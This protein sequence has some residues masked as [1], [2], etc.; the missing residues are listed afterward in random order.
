MRCLKPKRDF[1]RLTL[2]LVLIFRTQLT[3]SYEITDLKQIK[4][5]EFEITSVNLSNKG[6]SIF[7]E[8]I[9]TCPN[10]VKLDLS[11]NGILKIPQALS[12]MKELK[13]LNFSEN[14]GLSYL[15]LESLFEKAE[16]DLESLNLSDCQMGFI[17]YQIG[18]L[19]G[20]KILNVSGN[21]LND[22]PYPVT[23]LTK[24]EKV[25][26]SNNRIENLHW[27][28]GQWW[29]LK[30]LDISNNPSLKVN[31]LFLSLSVKESLEKLVISHI[32]ELPKNFGNLQ[33]NELVIKNTFMN[34]FPR[35]PTSKQIR[36]LS[37]ID[38][39]FRN[40]P[41]IVE[42]INENVQP[43][44]LRLKGIKF[45]DLQNFLNIS[46]DSVDISGNNLVDIRVL[47]GHKKLKWIDARGNNINQAS[48]QMFATNRPDIEIL[49][50]EPV[51]EMR[52][53]KP[54]IARFEPKPIVKTI[55]STKNNLVKIGRS[56]FTIP[57][58]TFLN[59]KGQVYEGSVNLAYTEYSTPASIFLSGIPMT[60]ESSGENLLFSSGGMFN[61]TASDQ[62][63]QPL[64]MNPTKEINVEMV[65]SSASP[66]MD[67]YQLNENGAWE[68]KGKDK[69]NEPFKLDMAK[70]DSISDAAFLAYSRK[71]VVIDE[72]RFLPMVQ[73]H[74]D[75]RSLIIS[76]KRIGTFE[77][78]KAVREDNTNF[79][80]SRPSESVRFI[81]KHSFIYD[82][83]VD[84]MEFYRDRL[85]S[86]FRTSI[87][88][89]RKFKIRRIFGPFEMHDW[90]V[91]YFRDL[92]I[93][94]DK[95]NDKMRMNFLYKDSLVSI[96]V[97]L[98]S[99]PANSKTR[100]KKYQFFF[101]EY[102][103]KLR[104]DKVTRD[105][106]NRQLKLLIKQSEDEVRELAA[107]REIL[108]QKTYFEN[109]AYL[110]EMAGVGSVARSFSIDGFGIW[111]CDQFQRL[112]EPTNIPQYYVDEDGNEIDLKTNV[113][114]KYVI[115]YDLNGVLCF[116][117]IDGFYDQSTKKMA[118]VIFFSP[119]KIGVY[120]SWHPFNEG[121]SLTNE[122]LP[123]RVL[124][125]S[126]MTNE[127]FLSYLQN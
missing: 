127:A 12:G 52:G 85:K 48:I 99:N 68:V 112:V 54:P 74:S 115:D 79:Y 2:L 22:L 78:R 27:Q 103:A 102:Y 21:L 109:A 76:F 7:P 81:E 89:Y 3:F 31:E 55:S 1:F 56:V 45:L 17:P 65:S 121:L 73:K 69:I 86:I 5:H 113:Q 46:V 71:A 107:K 62:D 94:L 75:T 97:V 32:V 83:D 23:N 14:Q 39:T 19:K 51:A 50:S 8:E 111:N 36:S 100:I 18:R 92:E 35:L 40:T 34:Q 57:E 114:N 125:L 123:L 43:E 49:I 25:D 24:L 118:I 91:N 10:L 4:G 33:V 20:L 66:E 117:G 126:K 87:R 37:F 38:C 29:N 30:Q 63:G 108:R 101:K 47:S 16:F 80:I 120:Q 98:Q 106:R 42:T 64:T 119:E 70:I 90:G 84:S 82:G 9:L 11:K 60:V 77:H 41:T 53:I 67:L 122:Q 6:Y 13:E 104:K 93:K 28:V 58:E 72:Y 110:Q 15:D 124:D 105:K 26:V 61:L 44:F 88:D 59:E 95:E 96:P 116:G